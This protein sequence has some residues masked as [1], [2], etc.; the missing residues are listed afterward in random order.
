[1]RENKGQDKEHQARPGKDDRHRQG[2]EAASRKGQHRAEDIT[3]IKPVQAMPRP[4]QGT[5]NEGR[6]DRAEERT[7]DT[8]EDMAEYRTEDRVDMADDK[9]A[10]PAEDRRRGAKGGQRT[11]TR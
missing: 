2:V 1:M 5:K 8:T 7:A 10:D 3:R 6:K 11:Q 4:G 9:T